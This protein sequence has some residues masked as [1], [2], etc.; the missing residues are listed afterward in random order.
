MARPETMEGE[1][2]SSLKLAGARG[3]LRTVLTPDDVL[4]ELNNGNYLRLSYNKIE[5]MR[6][7][8]FHIVPNWCSAI[9]ALL[10]YSSIRILN[11]QF[12]IW[13]GLI[14]ALLILS[15]LGFRKTALTIDSGDGGNYTL[16]GPVVDLIKFRVLTERIKDGIPFEKA[17]EG[18]NEVIMTEYPSSG[19]FEEIVETFED[20]I[21]VDS[22]PLALAMSDLIQNSKNSE[23]QGTLINSEINS[24]QES[25]VEMDLI[26]N[27]EPLFH[28]S[29]SRARKVQ[30]EMKTMPVH[31]GW[32]NV[33]NRT[34]VIRSELNNELNNYPQQN[35]QDENLDSNSDDSFDLFGFNL[36]ESPSSNNEKPFNMFG[37]DFD[38]V[39]ENFVRDDTNKSSFSMMP[40]SSIVTKNRVNHDV[41]DYSEKPFLSSF[42][43]TG[44]SNPMNQLGL[45]FNS[46]RNPDLHNSNVEKD[47]SDY[48]GIVS[49]AKDSVDVENENISPA[50]VD[51]LKRISFN[52]KNKNLRRLKLKK[53]SRKR[54]TLSEMIKSTIGFKTPKLLRSRTNK[55][56]ESTIT[57]SSRTSTITIDALKVQAHQSHEAQIAYA[58]KKINNEVD[59]TTEKFLAEISSDLVE[60]KIPTS[61]NDLTASNED[62]KD[63]LSTIGI[64]KFD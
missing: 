16:F 7:H 25:I 48:S 29:I 8:Q 22:D 28:G 9:G 43:E 23:N 6:H 45:N 3:S 36:E 56:N 55:D 61:F 13:I 59:E 40:E 4:L 37:E 62:K 34:E 31:S 26:E 33:A 50:L 46:V 47:N 18:L 41:N 27:R 21:A 20:E 32:S 1:V 52:D 11:G 42:Q 35:F 15:W 12:Q 58:L 19:I 2:I 60:V 49:I 14:G 64:S 63:I 17:C 57:E 38:E 44:F 30:S 54:L 51:G 24:N 39:N 5:A 10:I 53:N